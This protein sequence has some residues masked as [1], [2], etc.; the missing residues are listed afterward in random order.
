MLNHRIKNFFTKDWIAKLV[1]VVAT[2]ILWFFISLNQVSTINFPSK[3]KID[4]QGLKEG[5]VCTSSNENVQIKINADPIILKNLKESDF[6]AT[7]DL[8]G[9]DEG[10]YEKEIKTTVDSDKVTIISTNPRKT[11]II[12]E[13]KASK[14]VPVRARFDG[15]LEDGYIVSDS[16]ADPA[17]AEI[18]GP[19]SVVKTVSEVIAPIKASGEKQNFEKVSE[20]FAYDAQG[21]VLKAI[22]INPDT[23]K[24][25]ATVV[26]VGETKTVG[27]KAN[28]KGNLASGYWMSLVK[29]DP[30]V[31]TISGSKTKLTQTKY[32]ETEPI[33]I[34][35]LSENKTF[36]TALKKESGI[37]VEEKYSVIKVSIELSKI[38]NT[39]EI[40]IKP[41]FI[42]LA[43][44][45]KITTVDP[46]EAKISVSTDTG[47][48]TGQIVLNINANGLSKGEHT[49]NLT[50]SNFSLP[51]GVKLNKILTEK[52]IFKVE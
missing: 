44:D 16:V 29:T 21:N 15:K 31:I 8:T 48:D 47:A 26:P 14:N 38:E 43:K 40:S 27:I 4:Y 28:F 41:S 46:T 12:I 33:D 34:S 2:T 20:L 35:N 23:A 17:E 36:S 24:I 5:L 51:S 22:K 45:L 10:T 50:E 11:T 52:I 39:Q 3:I 1:I 13:K 9:L 25:T 18:V 6:K 42:N 37:S 49:A 30:Q 32:V 7:V 19:E